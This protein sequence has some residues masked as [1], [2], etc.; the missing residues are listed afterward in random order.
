[1][2][3]SLQASHLF[4]LSNKIALVTGGGTGIGLMIAKTLEANGAKVYIVGRRLNVLKKV[5]G[6][7]IIALQGDVS[8]RESVD[9]LVKSFPEDRLDILVNNAG[10]VYPGEEY[11]Q[12]KWRKTF[13]INLE[14]IHFMVAA[15]LPL[16]KATKGHPGKIINIGSTVTSMKNRSSEFRQYAYPVSKAGVNHLSKILAADLASENI[17]V[18]VI[19]PGAFPSEMFDKA[20]PKQLDKM[21]KY[22][23]SQRLGSNTDI[24]GVSLL[25]ASDAGDYITGQI[26][27]V[28]GGFWILG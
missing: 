24:G 6:G 17:T 4:D 22:L 5:S 13:Q 21:M 9:E 20:S 10:V 28:D 8:S 27:A 3:S 11:D 7:N 14:S 2:D 16:L 25:L 23:P 15:F 12:E 18:N 26:I 1:M 19:E